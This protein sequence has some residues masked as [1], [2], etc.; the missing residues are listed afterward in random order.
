MSPVASS[1]LAIPSS[2]RISRIVSSGTLARSIAAMN[3]SFTSSTRADESVALFL[4]VAC[5]WLLTFASSPVRFPWSSVWKSTNPALYLPVAMRLNCESEMSG[6]GLAGLLA[7][8]EM[9][10]G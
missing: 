5:T 2:R 10:T 7:E 6:R 8:C 3:A 1:S 4:P 9:R